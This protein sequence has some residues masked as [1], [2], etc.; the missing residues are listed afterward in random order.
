MLSMATTESLQ[1]GRDP[2]GLPALDTW[3]HSILCI[4]ISQATPDLRA[5]EPQLPDGRQS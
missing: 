3:A 5:R 1:A 4:T 2:F